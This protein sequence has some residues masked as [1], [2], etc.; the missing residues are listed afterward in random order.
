MIRQKSNTKKKSYRKSPKKKSQ[1]RKTSYRKKSYRKSHKKKSQNRKTSRM[2]SKRMKGLPYPIR[3]YIYM[4]SDRSF[5]IRSNE[6]LKIKNNEKKL[7]DLIKEIILLNYGEDEKS[8]HFENLREL[9]TE[10]LIRS[11]NIDKWD[12]KKI[13]IFSWDLSLSELTLL[14]DSFINLKIE[15]DLNLA[16]NQLKSLPKDFFS[17]IKIEGKLNLSG[18]DFD[19]EY[20]R[21]N[22]DNIMKNNI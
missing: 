20:Y 13:N 10:K 3:E 21:K 22:K 9:T 12:T 4:L 19:T 18:N 11:E 2:N 6:F 7:D 15:G 14:P 16:N 1:N 5:D 8:E 17:E